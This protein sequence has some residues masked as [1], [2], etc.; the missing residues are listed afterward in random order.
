[1]GGMLTGTIKKCVIPSA[2]TTLLRHLLLHRISFL[3]GS[4]LATMRAPSATG[5]KIS[6]GCLK[7]QS[8]G[9]TVMKRKMYSIP[10]VRHLKTRRVTLHALR[11]RR[12]LLNAASGLAIPPDTHSS[13]YILNIPNKPSLSPHV[14]EA[15]TV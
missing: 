10:V 7:R 6:E 15:A 1:M 4:M 13:G 2:S 3:R 8:R 11:L 12:C 14:F 5:V 9:L